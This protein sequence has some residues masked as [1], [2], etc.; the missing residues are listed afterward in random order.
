MRQRHRE[1]EGNKE[2]QRE[3]TIPSKQYHLL[4]KP[5]GLFPSKINLFKLSKYNSVL[6]GFFV[7]SAQVESS[8]FFGRAL[9]MIKLHLTECASL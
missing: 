6:V 8:R 4:F 3:Q 7:T 9:P 5:S 1:R 2:R